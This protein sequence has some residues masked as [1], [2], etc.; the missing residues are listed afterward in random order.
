[1]AREY[2]DS[3]GIS[4]IL[5]IIAK[6]GVSD[7]AIIQPLIN[8]CVKIFSVSKSFEP[9][10][11]SIALRAFAELDMD[12]ILPLAKACVQVSHLQDLVFDSSYSMV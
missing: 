4:S 3:H 8:A 2:C 1:M 9:R 7:L 6:L 12:S 5:N 10:Q 11:A